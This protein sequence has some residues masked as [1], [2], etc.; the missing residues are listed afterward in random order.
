[1]AVGI[2]DAILNS[3]KAASGFPGTFNI[4]IYIF[5]GDL[6]RKNISR[7]VEKNEIQSSPLADNK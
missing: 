5:P 1:M 3:R 4:L 6:F 2:L 7:N